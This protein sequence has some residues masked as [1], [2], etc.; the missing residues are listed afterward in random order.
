MRQFSSEV[1][2][3]EMK[4]R[5]RFN[6]AIVWKIKMSASRRRNRFNWESER[7]LW[8]IK[9][10]QK[11]K[12]TVIISSDSSSL[13]VYIKRIPYCGCKI[14]TKWNI[15]HFPQ[16]SWN[17]IWRYWKDDGLK[18]KPL[19]E[20]L[21]TDILFYT[22]ALDYACVSIKTRQ[23]TKLREPNMKVEALTRSLHGN[24]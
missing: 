10:Q 2:L 8:K 13:T 6:Q 12:K 4:P 24:S 1:L 15:S 19:G 7:T 16:L 21:F 17:R 18:I 9:A 3:R 14:T 23:S 20:T 11:K 5:E 22:G